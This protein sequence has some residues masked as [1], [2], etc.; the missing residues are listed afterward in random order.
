MKNSNEFIGI[1]FIRS[2]ISCGPVDQVHTII[3]SVR[4]R[5]APY[6]KSCNLVDPIIYIRT[7]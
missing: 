3:I 1:P 4:I 7:V 2:F 5:C 6:E